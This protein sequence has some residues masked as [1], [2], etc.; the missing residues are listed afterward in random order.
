[1]STLFVPSFWK[2]SLF[3]SVACIGSLAAVDAVCYARALRKC[4]TTPNVVWHFAET[5]NF[6]IYCWGRSAVDP[7]IG[8]RCE[9][10]RA[11]LADKWLGRPIRT[12]SPKCE[13]VIY[14]DDASYLRAVGQGGDH[15]LASALNEC[16]AGR[17]VRRRIDVRGTATDWTTA[18]LPHEMTHI[19][20]ADCFANCDLAPWLDESLAILADTATKQQAHLRDFDA[21][22]KKGEAIP[23]ADLFRIKDCTNPPCRAAFYGECVSLGQF[24]VG[25]QGERAFWHFAERALPDGVDPALRNVY[26]FDGV[27]DLQSRWLRSV[28][29]AGQ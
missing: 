16:E 23:L 3:L 19:L 18:A 20:A 1:M 14:P 15:T 13:V 29:R 8:A 11:Q 5:E 24:L 26:H 7:R 21:A 10:V 22:R 28:A 12:W 6:R 2:L 4:N 9:E 25:Q 17:V 27:G